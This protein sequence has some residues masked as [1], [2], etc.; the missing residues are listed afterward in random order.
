MSATQLLRILGEFSIGST[1]N[2]LI[3]IFFILIDCLLDIIDIVRKNS[4]YL[5]MGEEEVEHFL[6]CKP[7]R[8]SRNTPFRYF[9]I[10]GFQKMYKLF[11]VSPFP[12]MFPVAL[13]LHFI[14]VL[15]TFQKA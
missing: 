4:V 11:T 3:D 12:V 6:A 8:K 9:Q 13:Q 15:N 5:L 1:I 7:L 14:S 10:L 2:P